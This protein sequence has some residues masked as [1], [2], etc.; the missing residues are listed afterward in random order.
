MDRFWIHVVLFFVFSLLLAM[1]DIAALQIPMLFLVFQLPPAMPGIYTTIWAA[2]S[3]FP[4]VC[5]RLQTFPV[6]R[7]WWTDISNS[8]NMINDLKK[9][10]KFLAFSLELQTVFSIIRTGF[11]TVATMFSMKL[12]AISKFSRN[13]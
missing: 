6:I 8:S 2:L 12:K 1:P 10:C 4:S 9:C 5:L 13:A 11:F 3:V 7:F